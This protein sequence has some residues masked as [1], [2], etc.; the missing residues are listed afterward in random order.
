MG[1]ARIGVAGCGGR[2]GRMLLA[3]IHGSAGAEI[4]GG[5]EAAGSPAIGRD[6]GELAGLGPVGIAAGDDPARV[7]AASDVVLDFTAPAAS[8]AHAALAAE[9]GKALVLGTT[10][11]DPA[12]GKAVEAA[13]RRAPIVWAANTSLGI[14]L[15]AALVEEAARRLGPDWDIEVLE[16]H[17]K[18][19]VDAPS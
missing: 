6:L 18:H 2:M 10:G 5:F 8:V 11:L 19:K 12:Q 1:K 7:F 16:M 14:T 17:H 4:A 13:A 9:A 3:E 15:L